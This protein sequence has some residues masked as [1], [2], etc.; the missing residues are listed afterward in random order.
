MS[1]L[2]SNSLQEIFNDNFLQERLIF[3][4]IF[5]LWPKVLLT[6]HDE[7]Y[8]RLP[9]QRFALLDEDFMEWNFFLEE[10]VL[11]NDLWFGWSVFSQMFWEKF[12]ATMSKLLSKYREDSLMSNEN[13]VAVSSKFFS[14]V[15]QDVFDGRYFKLSF[16]LY[17]FSNFELKSLN[18]PQNV[19][20][21]PTKLVHRCWHCF[22]TLFRKFFVTIYFKKG[23]IFSLFSDVH[24][25][26]FWIFGRVAKM[27]FSVARWKLHAT[28]I[29]L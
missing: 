17:I 27:A 19:S 20:T 23:L 25:N 10:Y 4:F 22:L 24:Q 29:F 5:G 8:A 26:F 16:V 15:P 2:L 6:F 13:F 21:L 11:S 12:R 14:A 7:L 3:F 28:K 18:F 1:T 9:K